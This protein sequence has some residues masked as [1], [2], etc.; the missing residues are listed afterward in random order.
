VAG[1]VVDNERGTPV[2]QAPTLVSLISQSNPVIT[3]APVLVAVR[4]PVAVSIRVTQAPILTAHRAPNATGVRTTQ[5]AFLVAGTSEG[6][7][8][9]RVTQSALLIATQD[10]IPGQTRQRA[11]TFDFDGH[12]F[13]VLDLSEEGT[14][15]LDLTT[16]QWSKFE[17]PGHGSWNMIN[18][19]FWESNRMVVAGDAINPNVNR[20]DPTSHLDDGWRPVEYKVS[21]GIVSRGRDGKRLSSLRMAVSAGHVGDPTG[22][23]SITMK[24]SD[25]NGDTWSND[26]TTTILTSSYSQR[27]E[28]NSL[29]LIKNPG[30]VFEFSDTGGLVRIDGVEA[31]IEG[32]E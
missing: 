3:Q 25:D 30:R 1:E 20:L 21:G 22:T 24:F 29:G 4:P 12:S 18:G 15:V 8:Q 11:W 19:L 32:S 27:I 14:W 13:Y 23:P 26:Y 16:M 7:V 17:T 10:G 2:T 9:V 6:N 5:A 28:W 31:Q